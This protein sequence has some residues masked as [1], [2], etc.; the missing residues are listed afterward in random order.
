LK[1]AKSSEPCDDEDW[2]VVKLKT[3]IKKQEPVVESVI[4]GG[5]LASF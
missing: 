5:W 3:T 2:Q 4:A 1:Y